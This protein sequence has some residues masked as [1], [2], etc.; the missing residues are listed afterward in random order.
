MSLLF[1]VKVEVK[2]KEKNLIERG[3]IH[4]VMRSEGEVEESL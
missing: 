2:S 3:N 4:N 1:D